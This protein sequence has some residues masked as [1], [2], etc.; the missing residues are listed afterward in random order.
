V[1]SIFTYSFI[2][3]DY[4]KKYYFRPMYDLVLVTQRAYVKPLIDDDYHRNILMEDGLLVKALEIH[5]LS[6]KRVAWDDESFDWN[7]TKMAVI[8]A[9]WD[10]FHRIDEFRKWL[11]EVKA[12]TTLI[13]PYETIDWN[14]DKR[15][16]KDMQERGVNIPETCF[17][18]AGCTSSLLELCQD[19]NWDRWVL[20]PAISGAAR[21]TY[22][23]EPDTIADHEKVFSSLIAKEH[24]LLQRFQPNV[25]LLGEWTFVLING[26]YTHAVLKRAKAGDF[27][28]QD[29]FGGTVH[30]HQATHE[31]I[32][33]AESAMAMVNPIPLYGRVDVI[34]DVNSR[35]ALQE[36]ELIEPELWFRNAPDAVTKLAKELAEICI[37]QA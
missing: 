4:P 28:V 15:Y 6:V 7:S 21:H 8:R 30:D 20:K 1:Q 5:G 36:L 18:D 34:R 35:L 29:D 14:L 31:E 16:L 24:M 25:T 22:L 23:I 11:I 3:L 33:F 37:R 17:I 26:K 19:T 2:D 12:K 32:E 9:T 27:R 10:Y 13:N